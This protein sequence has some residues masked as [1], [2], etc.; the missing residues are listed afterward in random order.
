MIAQA[1]PSA[2]ANSLTSSNAASVSLML[3]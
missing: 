1:G 3:L 2:G